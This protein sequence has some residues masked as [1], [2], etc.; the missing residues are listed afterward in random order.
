[1]LAF[2]SAD[3]EKTEGRLTKLM[4]KKSTFEP[5]TA[6]CTPVMKE[7]KFD[8]KLS[9]LLMLNPDMTCIKQEIYGEE[10]ASKISSEE[11]SKPTLKQNITKLQ[12]QFKINTKFANSTKVLMEPNYQPDSACTIYDV[13]PTQKY[14]TEVKIMEPIPSAFNL[15]PKI[16]KRSVF[17]RYLSDA[18]MNEG[19]N[20]W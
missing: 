17:K 15:P 2:K 19:L 7:E 4:L 6:N 20:L 13:T 12:K 14:E 3:P 9:S 18:V 10:N 5:S 11:I 16:C 1:M 8:N